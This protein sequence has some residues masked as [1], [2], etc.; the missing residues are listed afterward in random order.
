VAFSAD[1]AN[2]E[3][4]LRNTLRAAPGDATAAASLTDLLIA[5][6]R[7]GEACA[8]MAPFA[9]RPGAGIVALTAAG[10]ALK[11]CGRLDEAIGLYQRARAAAPTSAVAEHNLGAALG[12][13]QRF[14]ESKSAADRAFAKGL[15]APETWLVRARALQGLGE[16]DAA[17]HA[18]REAIRRRG[19]FDD[20]IGDL[21]QLIWMRTGDL[22]KAAA[23]LDA[24]LRRAQDPALL[25]KLA[26][27]YEYAGDV[28]GAYGVLADAAR[29]APR[30][31]PLQVQAAQLASGLDPGRALEHARMALQAAPT[32]PIVL[33]TL[34]L[35]QLA[36]GLARDAERTALALCERAPDNQHAIALLATAWRLLGDARYSALFDYDSL[37]SA[38]T[39]DTPAGWP[40]LADYLAD[41]AEALDRRHLYRAHPIGQSVR[42]GSQT[43]QTLTLSN[44]PTIRAFF[45]AIDGP[46]RRH[47]ANLGRGDDALRRRIGADYRL[48]SVW[49]V[50]LEPGGSHANHVHQKGWL[51]SACYISLPGAVESGHEGW[52]KL[53]EPG[54]ATNPPLAP[55]RFVRPEP[56]LLVLFPSY[57]WHGVVPFGG[58]ERRLSVAFDAAPA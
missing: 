49:S 12:D 9:A 21:A 58:A 29:V 32:A 14:A 19:G 41:L 25:S 52:L 26:S 57:M 17:E 35:A 43:E 40:R 39:I 16:L 45:Q 50:R 1:A 2:Q 8:L 18:Y 3:A 53:G 15:D 30:N 23:P 37:V 48:L 44:D 47:I 28:A 13:A 33:I 56:G 24:A 36:A 11:A 7:P 55:E 34:C 38:Q 5:T 54:V 20:A 42:G 4:A 46:I 51:S 22:A 31:W 10:D 6:G 27:L